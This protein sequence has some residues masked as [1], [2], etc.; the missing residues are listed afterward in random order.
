MHDILPVN[1]KSGLGALQIVASNS[2]AVIPADS[3]GVVIPP[4]PS[5]AYAGQCQVWCG[6]NDVTELATISLLRCMS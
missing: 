4:V 6:A 2:V 1:V 5:E 3:S